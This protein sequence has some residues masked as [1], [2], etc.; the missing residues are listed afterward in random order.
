[1]ACR[2]G[3]FPG[4][5]SN[6]SVSSENSELPVLAVGVHPLP[7]QERLQEAPEFLYGIWGFDLI[8]EGLGKFWRWLSQFT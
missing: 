3:P 7:L 8:E 2:L 5:K 6:L 1:M 4:Q